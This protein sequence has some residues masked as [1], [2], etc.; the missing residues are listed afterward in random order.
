MSANDGGRVSVTDEAVQIRPIGQDEEVVGTA[1]I[2]DFGHEIERDARGDPA[3]R[4]R[5]IAA[6]DYR[7]AG[8]ETASCDPR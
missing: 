8:V 5:V 1:P 2:L 4:Q 6:Q 3:E 7:R